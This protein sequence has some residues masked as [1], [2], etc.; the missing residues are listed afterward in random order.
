MEE[1]WERQERRPP[2]SE[3]QSSGNT[4]RQTHTWVEEEEEEH[5]GAEWPREE[6]SGEDRWRG[7][8]KFA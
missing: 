7:Q 2:V 1:K 4:A 5:S 6:K 8:M 3:R